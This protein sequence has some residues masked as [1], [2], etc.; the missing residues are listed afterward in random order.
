MEKASEGLTHLL[1]LLFPASH[2]LSVPEAGSSHLIPQSSHADLFKCRT[3]S[4]LLPTSPASTLRQLLTP[5]LRVKSSPQS[6]HGPYYS[7]MSV[8][9]T[10]WVTL[11]PLNSFH[12]GP[13]RWLREWLRAP[14]SQ[15]GGLEFAGSQIPE[16]RLKG[17][18]TLFWSP[19]T[20]AHMCTYIH[21]NT[22]KHKEN[23]I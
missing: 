18:E 10:H 13:E 6:L 4:H 16:T 7:I 17:S 8:D 11:V 22:H 9:S 2:T 5:S 15:S 20:P 1:A 3:D 14:A 23:K 19:L 12:R 21:S